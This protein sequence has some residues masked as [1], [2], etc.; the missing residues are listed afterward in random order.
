M[1]SNGD[2]L[3]EITKTSPQIVVYNDKLYFYEIDD[4]G[5][6]PKAQLYLSDGTVSGTDQVETGL[7]SMLPLSTTITYITEFNDKTFFPA[8]GEREVCETVDQG[9]VNETTTCD[10]VTGKVLFVL[11]EGSSQARQFIEL[12]TFLDTEDDSS[13]IMV[14]DGLLYF[15][16]KDGGMYRTDG[17]EEGTFALPVDGGT[18][19]P[20]T[21]DGP[22]LFTCAEKGNNH[23]KSICQTDGTINGTSFV[24]NV[25]SSTGFEKGLTVLGDKILFNN[26][27]KRKD[28]EV[29]PY[30]YDQDPTIVKEAKRLNVLGD[31]DTF[32]DDHST[33]VIH[34]DAAFFTA[35]DTTT[36]LEGI[37]LYMTNGKAPHY[38]AV[39]VLVKDVNLASEGSDVRALGLLDD[40][41]YFIA[42]TPETGSNIWK[43]VPCPE[44]EGCPLPPVEDVEAFFDSEGDGQGQTNQDGNSTAANTPD[45]VDKSEGDTIMNPAASTVYIW[46]TSSTLLS[47]VPLIMAQVLFVHLAGMI[48]L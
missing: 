17:T 7:N 22:L 10:T 40:S 44:E 39:P 4:T 24:V 37:Q 19:T 38:L 45:N 30:V 9:T 29:K 33:Y 12:P 35:N 26:R 2:S 43:V 6:K 15:Q 14:H 5:S 32:E 31:L 28:V 3:S 8:N 25:S 20:T 47:S 41:L 27:K 23:L 42:Y 48:V 1:A 36:P 46:S 21:D 16:T 11:E 13:K 18:F 34:K